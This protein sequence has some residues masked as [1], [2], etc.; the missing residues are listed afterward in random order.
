MAIQTH[1]TSLSQELD[2]LSHQIAELE[3][4][5]AANRAEHGAKVAEIEVERQKLAR[6]EVSSVPSGVRKRLGN[7]D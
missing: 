7:T 2:T 1:V 3:A 4:G 6:E 5:L